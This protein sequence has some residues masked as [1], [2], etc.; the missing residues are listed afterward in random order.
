MRQLGKSDS[1]RVLR[2][3]ATFHRTHLVFP[4]VLEMDDEIKAMKQ[5]LGTLTKLTPEG[6]ERVMAFVI[7]FYADKAATLNQKAPDQP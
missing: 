1:T 3:A 6:R 2:K 4:E 5:I 7:S